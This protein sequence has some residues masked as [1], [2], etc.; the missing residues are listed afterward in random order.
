[1]KNR[2]N[3]L[4]PFFMKI[5]INKYIYFWEVQQEVYLYTESLNDIFKHIN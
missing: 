4:V 3:F 1:M 2:F 5:K